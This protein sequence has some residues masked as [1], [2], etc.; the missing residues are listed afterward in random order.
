VLPGTNDENYTKGID[1]LPAMAKEFYDLGCRFAKC[2]AVLKI[3]GGCPSD[4]AIKENAWNLARY[5]AICQENGLVPIVEP[6]ILSDG[7]HSAEECQRVTEKVL[8]ATFKALHD[9]NVILEGCLLKP[10]MVTYGSKHAKKNDNN[11]TEEARRTVRALS[12]TVPAALAGIVFL[13]G[14]QSEEQASL[15][16]SA[17][18]AIDNI[19]KPWFVSFSFGRALQNSA[20]KAWGG[21]DETLDAGQ[22][23]FLVR[24]KAN[25]EAQLGKYKGSEDKAANESL[26]QEAYKY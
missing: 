8:V 22:K 2:R 20:I 17:M 14:G 24:A 13:S 11:V 5:A 3:G 10:N 12:R 16:L 15:Q 19:R 21:H 9:N 4:L 18:N 1:T 26:F 25:S 23:A 6:E 7:E